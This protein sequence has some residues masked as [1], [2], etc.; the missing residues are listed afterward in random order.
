MPSH[1]TA[2]NWQ[3]EHMLE[4]LPV[5]AYVCDA[6]GQLTYYNPAALQ[7]WGR[8]PQLHHPEDRF[9]GALKL[10]DAAGKALP[11][12]GCSMARSLRE[13]KSV[14]Q[15]ECIE[16]PDGSQLRVLAKASPLPGEHGELTGAVA[17]LLDSRGTPAPQGE[18]L[19]R[20][21]HDLRTPINAIMG[22]ASL[23]ERSMGDTQRQKEFLGVLKVSAQQLLE[24]VNGM[25]DDRPAAKA[26][27]APLPQAATP[28]PAG[29]GRILVAEDYD[30]NILVVTSMLSLFGYPYEVAKSGRE[31][32]EWLRKERFALVLMDV[33]MPGMNGYD[34][35][36]IIRQLQKSGEIAPTPIVGMTAHVLKGDKEKCLKAGMDDY[37]SKPFQPQALKDKL[38][39]HLPEHAATVN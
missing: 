28:E 23:L 4:H 16:R 6:Q 2:A 27:A 38:A 10:Q 20:L 25:Q 12:E 9:N 21:C 32:V 36:H 33:E 35:T 29:A 5:A 22:L 15:E 3:H 1:A 13:G 31:A 30:A 7:L 26:A 8:T 37:I 18:A 19:A 24:M 14:A 11:H 39:S 17:V 34:A